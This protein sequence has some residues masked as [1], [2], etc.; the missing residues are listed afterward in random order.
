M[1]LFREI[2]GDT[3]VLEMGLCENGGKVYVYCEGGEEKLSNDEE[4]ES[5]DNGIAS[6]LSFGV[7]VLNHYL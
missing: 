3:N 2:N 6:E 7:M 5:V 1:S 4:E